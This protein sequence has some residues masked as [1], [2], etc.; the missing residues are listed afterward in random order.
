M[1]Q[2]LC[3]RAGEVWEGEAGEPGLTGRRHICQAGRPDGIGLVGEGKEQV[4]RCAG[5]KPL[6]FPPDSASPRYHDFSKGRWVLGVG[7]CSE[8]HLRGLGPNSASSC[9][10]QTR[11][12]CSLHVSGLLP[13]LP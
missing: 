1:G 9:R 12:R 10:K 11:S 13:A 6:A 3:R 8:G 2:V 5:K 4:Q 7:D